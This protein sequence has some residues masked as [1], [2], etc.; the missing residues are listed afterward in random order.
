MGILNLTPDSFYD[1]AQLGVMSA[2]H[3]VPDPNKVL[4][5]AEAMLAEGAQILD[6]GGESTRP[7]AEAVS[8]QQELDRVMPIVEL[9]RARFD[10]C[11]SVDTSSPEVMTAAIDLG[12]HL[13]ND[14]R[15][16]S[17]NGALSAVT[18]TKAGLC[19]MH[20]QGQPLT[21]QQKV[22]YEDVVAEV[23]DFLQARVI[24][25]IAAGIDKDRLV[26]DPGF[27][28]GKSTVHN[29]RLLRHLDRL[30]SIGVP[31]LAGLSR[32]SMLGA[33][34]GRAVEGRLAASVAAAS[35]ALE[36]GAKIIRAHDVAATMDAIRVH[37]ACYNS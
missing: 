16:F 28:F 34:T 32:K 11:L 36:W 15:C 14:I 19:L 30:M 13:I 37:C 26:I 18:D 35:L 23:A 8:S 1:G 25:C 2:S 3:F 5:R 10:V 7:G 12:V 22:H 27:G 24:S 4:R 31:V 21:M 6:I 29:Y 9:L 33:V 17:R 20:M